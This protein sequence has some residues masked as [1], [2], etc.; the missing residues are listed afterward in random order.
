M[1]SRVVPL[2]SVRR[3]LLQGTALLAAVGPVITGT[4]S[5]SRLSAQPSNQPIVAKPSGPKFEVASIKQA[6]TPPANY[7][8]RTEPGRVD[9]GSWS[10]RQLI[11]RAYGLPGYR[12]SAP[13]W[14]GD[15]RF[16]VVATYPKEA[17]RD[18]LPEMLQ[19]LLADRFGLAAHAE[20]RELSSFALVVGKGGLKMKPAP[21]ADA[22]PEPASPNRLERAGQLMDRLASND[23][24]AF[25]VVSIKVVAGG[26]H[27]EFKSLPMEALAQILADRLQA[28]V[29]N[30]THL[31]GE[32]QVTL[33]LP[34][35]GSGIANITPE[36]Q[37]ESVSPF[38]T[39]ERLGLKLQKQK[40]PISLLVVEHLDRVPTQN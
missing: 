21:P 19:W 20:T 31:E 38:S 35:P 39:V 14:I 34:P 33:E 11:L 26:L 22:Q 40:T 37:A 6:P 28:P 24:K 23:P 9:I 32:Y 1:I 17:T 36:S 13:A 15:S 5:A 27:A 7:H 29:I 25:G 4:M 18:Q 30:M 2:S 10:L 8:I 16:D 3:L 12:L